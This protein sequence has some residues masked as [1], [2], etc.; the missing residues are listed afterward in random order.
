MAQ[1][2]SNETERE[3][4]VAL[5]DSIRLEDINQKAEMDKERR[6]IRSV[7]PIFA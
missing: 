6:E 2:S 3:R 5:M 4:L 7:F 1:Q